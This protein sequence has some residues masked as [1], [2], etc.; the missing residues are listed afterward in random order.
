VQRCQL[1]LVVLLS[2]ATASCARALAKAEPVMPELVP[3][4][5]PPRVVEIYIDEPVPTVEPGPAETALNSPP[6]RPPARP[7]VAKPDPPK[8]EPARPE[9]E[10]ASPTTPALTLKQAP[11]A[12]ASTVASI[13][14]LLGLAQ[15]DLNRV[16]YPALDVDG[17]T[18]YDT[19]RRFMQQ[20]ED[21]LRGG[22]LVFA[23]KLADKA[24]TMAA[25]LVR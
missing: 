17:R 25:V 19:A 14:N 6:V 7:P 18:Q 16:N 4:P 3:P 11:G 5:P 9:P 23:G 22:N 13:R 10:K 1:G 21:A 2:L 20:A 15:K 12:S 24:A 8:P